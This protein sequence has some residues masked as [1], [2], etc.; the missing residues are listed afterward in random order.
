MVEPRRPSVVRDRSYAP[1]LAVAAVS[2]GAFMGQL[3]ASIV[4]VALPRIQAELGVS[5]GAVE[6]VALAYLLTLIACV[7]GVGQLADR[8]GRKLCYVYG[9]ALF[10]LASLGAG[11][12]SS[13]AALVVFRVLQGV[14]AAMLQANSVA[15]IATSV[16]RHRLGRAIGVQGAAQAVGL[17]LGPAVGTLVVAHW[18]WPAI[19]LLNVPVAAVGI[20][21]G[22][23]FLP[24]TREFCR[25]PFRWREL[26]TSIRAP[27]RGLVAGLGSYAVLF[28]VLFLIPFTYRGPA[29]GWVL[30]ALPAF[31]AVTAPIAGAF[32]RRA[33][34]GLL[35]AAAGL[36]AL[37]W[38]GGHPLALAGSLA[39]IGVGIGA[40]TPANSAGIMALAPAGR[41]G[42]TSGILNMTRGLGTAAGVALTGAVYTASASLPVAAYALAAVALLAAF[43]SRPA[44]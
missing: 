40:F 11:L 41:A 14:G 34:V 39:V 26:A 1:W 15:L 44:P 10:G 37:P 22:L 17:A 7:I 8:Y 31:I 28:G 35:I 5:V 18:G 43:V 20:V 2:I 3:D 27:L 24:R 4:T 6:W 16:P 12:S 25:T 30:T 13:L 19:F 42:L 9:F 21:L 33:G 38:A 36:A 29:A 32:V 23:A